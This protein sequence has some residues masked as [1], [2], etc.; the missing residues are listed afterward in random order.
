MVRAGN[1]H[2]LGFGLDLTQ[3]ELQSKLNSAL[4]QAKKR[5][6]IIRPFSVLVRFLYN[7]FI[8]ALRR[9]L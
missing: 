9:L 7:A 6:E 5:P 1:L 4:R 3:G 8:C 2:A